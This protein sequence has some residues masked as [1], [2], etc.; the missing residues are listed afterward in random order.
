MTDLVKLAQY[1]GVVSILVLFLFNF[2]IAVHIVSFRKSGRVALLWTTIYVLFLFCL[3]VIQLMN[4]ATSEQLRIISG[5][6]AVIPLVGVAYHL[7]LV[8]KIENPE[9]L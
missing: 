5:F 7:F 3:R 2:Y 9:A 6:T 4:I 1:I 8:R